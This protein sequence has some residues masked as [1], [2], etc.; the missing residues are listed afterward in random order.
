M[1]KRS[2]GDEQT[3]TKKNAGPRDPKSQMA[4]QKILPHL[5][6]TSL[7]YKEIDDQRKK[8]RS[9]QY[10]CY[11][12]AQCNDDKSSTK[13]LEFRKTEMGKTMKRNKT[14]GKKRNEGNSP[15]P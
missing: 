15:Q 9:Q 4:I 3:V 8:E 12:I 6:S 2:N 7:C 5:P 14:L 11:D 1:I 13:I 10:H